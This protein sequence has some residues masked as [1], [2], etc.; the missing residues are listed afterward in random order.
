MDKKQLYKVLVFLYK[1][2][3]YKNKYKPLSKKK[4]LLYNKL[5]HLNYIEHIGGG[6]WLSDTG[7]KYIEEFKCGSAIKNKGTINSKFMGKKQIT[8]FSRNRRSDG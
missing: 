3:K 1:K 2:T 5:Y 8:V 6:Y 4:I 7:K